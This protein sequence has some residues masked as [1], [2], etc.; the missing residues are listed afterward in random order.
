MQTPNKFKKNGFSLTSLLRVFINLLENS[1]HYSEENSTITVSIKKI[2]SSDSEAETGVE[3]SVNDKSSGIPSEE[4][5]RLTERFYRV[6][7]ARGS[8][9]PGFGLGLSL[10]RVITLAHGGELILKSSEGGLNSFLM[11]IPH[12]VS[13]THLTLPTKA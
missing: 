2:F 6:D 7:P 1:L 5:P 13:Y 12:T 3:I 11:T 4:I 8:T 10:A 9:K